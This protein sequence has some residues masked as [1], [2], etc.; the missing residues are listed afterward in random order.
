MPI[1]HKYDLPPFLLGILS[2]SAYDKWLN[3]KADSLRTR[4]IRLKRPFPE[5]CSKA[6]YKQ[7]I[8]AAILAGG[9]KDPYTGD[10][11]RWDLVG[12]WDKTK[13]ALLCLPPARAGLGKEYFLMPTVDHCDPCADQLNFEICSWIVNSSK[14]LMNP[15]EYVDLCRKVAGNRQACA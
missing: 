12:A 15:Q 13:E 2:V 4:D 8:H 6:I 1:I 14:T 7:K 5:T 3:C 11:L 10:A 9:E